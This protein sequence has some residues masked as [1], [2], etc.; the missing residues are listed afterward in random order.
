MNAG[1]CRS[2]FP[3]SLI[4]VRSSGNGSRLGE[5]GLSQVDSEGTARRFF[6]I[7]RAVYRPFSTWRRPLKPLAPHAAAAWRRSYDRLVAFVRREGH[8]QVPWRHH[9]GGCAL[10]GWVR[11]QRAKWREDRLLEE[12]RQ[13]LE[14]VPGWDWGPEGMA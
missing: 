8:T 2:L 5:G 1:F 10:G 9:E 11:R 12:H 7:V 3:D 13:L 4:V 14:A 6:A